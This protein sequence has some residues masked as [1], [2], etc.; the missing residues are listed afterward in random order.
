[1]MNYEI[2]KVPEYKVNYTKSIKKTENIDT[3]ETLLNQDCQYHE[4]LLKNDNLKLNTDIDKLKEKNPNADFDKICGDICEYLGVEFNDLSY[5]TN[6]SVESGSHHIV[7]PKYYMNSCEQKLLWNDFRNKYGYG[8][9]IDADVLGKDSWFRLP[10]QT[11][12]G[13][14]NTKHIINQ[15]EMKDFVLKYIEEAE[16]Y[17]LP[18]E[19][20]KKSSSIKLMKVKVAS[21]TTNETDSDDDDEFVKPVTQNQELLDLIIIDKKDRKKWF[22]ICSFIKN[23]KMTNDDWLRFCKNNELNMDEEKINL[24]KNLTPLNIEI[25]YLRALAK[26]SN[27]EKYKTWLQKWEIYYIKVEDIDDPHKVAK[28]ISQTL[29]EE[30]ILC[31]EKWYVLNEKKLWKQQKEPSYYIINELRKY[32]DES[33]KIIVYKI[34]KT[35]GK[36]KDELI[37][38]SKLYLKTYKTICSSGYLNVLTKF[39]RTLLIDDKFMDKLDANADKLA[40]QN[41]IMDLKTKKFRKGI[42][43]SDFITDTI[44]FNYEI[45]KAT[46]EKKRFIKNVLL[47]ILNNNEE[48]LEY[49]LSIIGFTFIGSPHLEKSLYFCVDKTKK[50]AGDNGKTFFFDILTTLMPNYVYKSKGTL[51]EE[52]N[53]KI[54]KQL[55]MMNGKRLVWVDE[56]GTNKSNAV[57]MKE[58]GDGLHIENEVM[59]GTSD[60]INVMFKLFALTNHLPN[61]DPKDT[62]VYNRYKQISYGSHFDRTGNRTEEDPDNLLFIANVTL[63]DT[64]KSDYYNE[65]FELIIEYANKYYIDKIPSIPF[66][67]IKDTTETQNKNDEFG[68]WFDDNIIIDTNERISKIQM[69]KGT[70]MSLKEIIEGMTRKGFEYKKALNCGKDEFKNKIQGGWEGCKII[71]NDGDEE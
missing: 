45:G 37:E 20:Q 53:T 32:I 14:K 28:I 51:L 19:I 24:L 46:A 18:F 16:E 6:Y 67:F 35:E 47:K 8:K 57:L 62:A 9:E 52:K 23:N 60:N 70:N 48:H 49:F 41:G 1:M 31:K 33:N 40:F 55:V 63:G 43:S 65:I 56:F 38:K 30:L 69:L 26:E 7:I 22:S 54:H 68:L 5:T 27:P 36:Q 3:I 11:K 29:K 13:V 34:S 64:I 58:L 17:K 71:F 4:R 44:P 25:Y 10:N 61:I 21:E 39:L 2:C 66:Q 42:L 59:F 12:E 15:G 50:C